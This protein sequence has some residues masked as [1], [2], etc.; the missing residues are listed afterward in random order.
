H[1][2]ISNDIEFYNLKGFFHFED[3]KWLW[4]DKD[5]SGEMDLFY[6]GKELRKSFIC[7]FSGRTAKTGE[8]IR[9]VQGL[10]EGPFWFCPVPG[11]LNSVPSISQF[12]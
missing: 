2:N 8:V 10:K 1:M 9:G 3:S 6:G 5:E 12:L 7:G 11:H 4:R